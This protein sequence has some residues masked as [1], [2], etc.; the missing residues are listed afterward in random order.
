MNLPLRLEVCCGLESGI[1]QQPP[2]LQKHTPVTMTALDALA[3]RN[4]PV[5][6]AAYR[7]AALL[8]VQER[9]LQDT[10]RSLTIL[11]S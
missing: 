9:L 11:P 1:E 10:G 2:S 8:P 5:K 7:H 3:W 6:K 4:N